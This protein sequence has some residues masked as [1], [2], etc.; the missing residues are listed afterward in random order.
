MFHND[1]VI[2]EARLL[3][4]DHTT[5]PSLTRTAVVVSGR[6]FPE[7]LFDDYGQ[8]FEFF[9]LLLYFL[10]TDALR[11]K[12]RGCFRIIRQSNIRRHFLF[13]FFVSSTARVVS[14]ENKAAG[15]SE[16]ADLNKDTSPDDGRITRK[17]K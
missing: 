15:I 11:D 16:R 17:R 7:Q 12:W 2:R 9:C 1:L 5:C 13:F 6:W 3:R 8:S 4:V 10:S 14:L